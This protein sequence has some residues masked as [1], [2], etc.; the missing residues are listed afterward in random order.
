MNNPI[1][2]TGNDV[3]HVFFF[4]N[5]KIINESNSWR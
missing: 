4:L 1:R 3:L 2:K 5:I